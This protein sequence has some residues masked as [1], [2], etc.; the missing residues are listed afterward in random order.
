M[1]GFFDDTENTTSPVVKSFFDDTENIPNQNI[2]DTNAPDFIPGVQRGLQNLKASAYG[3]TA[4]AGKGLK[5]LGAESVGQKLQD[6][7]ME[8]YQ[9]NIEEAKLYPAKH[10]F[11]DVYTGEAGVG[12]AIDW[13][14]G[15]LGELIPSMVEAAGGAAIGSLVAPGAGTAVGGLAGRTILKKGIDAAAEQAVKKGIKN[16]AEDQLKK[17]LTQSALTKLG[18]KVG[19]AAATM[20]IESGSMYAEL[21]SEKGIDAPGTATLFGALATSLEFAGGNSKLVDT[22]I[23][24]L[25]NGSGKIAKKSAK[26]ILSNIPQE[27]L[28]EGGQEVMAILNTVVNTDEELL[29]AGNVERIIES[30]AAGAVGG[31]AGSVMSAATNRG[32]NVETG[33]E[34]QLTDKE[35]KLNEQAQNILSQDE[36]RLSKSMKD[37]NAEIANNQAILSDPDKFDEQVKLLN[38]EPAEL[39]AQ[40]LAKNEDNKYLLNQINSSIKT[41]KEEAVQKAREEYEALTPKQKA[42]RDVETKLMDQRISEAQKIDSGLKDLDKNLAVL[43]PQYAQETDQAK[44]DLLGKQI[45]DLVDEQKSL[46]GQQEEIKYQIERTPE[47]SRAEKERF[48]NE[49]WGDVTY[50]V[51]DAKES[52]ET[53]QANPNQLIP[54]QLADYANQIIA[55]R[56]NKVQEINEQNAPKTAEETR[57][58]RHIEDYVNYLQTYIND[59]FTPDERSLIENYWQG[60]K[61]ELASTQE[62]MTPGTEAFLRKKFFETKLDEIEGNVKQDIKQKT[63]SEQKVTIP[64]NEQYKRQQWFQKVAKE[65]GDFADVNNQTVSQDNVRNIPGEQQLSSIKLGSEA[66][67]QSE[68][69]ESSFTN[70]PQVTDEELSTIKVKLSDKY[71]GILDISAKQA[72]EMISAD[73]TLHERLRGCIG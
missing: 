40:T 14:Q 5:N 59:S 29:T 42:V 72:L 53:I 51:K 17:E 6:V 49:V 28:Q 67:V 2:T 56:A 64:L 9:R 33:K 47:L 61:K 50:N 4:L 15:T 46:T 34:V 43:R 27:A 62:E 48:Y 68:V 26:E 3:A 54:K 1:A 30:M 18:G 37:L 7:G 66:G 22:F 44:K 12:G 10:T 20:P 71:D 19:I 41:R 16:I 11:K 73:E 13:A 38:I 63:T 55:S 69:S 8:G 31:G 32:S 36:Q 45:L 60:V 39:I 57:N 21:L 24:G 58:L 52:A 23:D 35:L 25:R 65:L 70:E